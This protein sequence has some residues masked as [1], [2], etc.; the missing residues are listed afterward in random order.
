MD[1]RVQ[2]QY[3]SYPYPLRSPNDDLS[4]SHTISTLE[5]LRAVNHYCFRGQ[6]DWTRPFR[7]LVAGGGTGDSSTALGQQLQAIGCEGEVVY[8]DLSKTSLKIARDRAKAAGLSNVTFL[9]GSLLEVG[10]M[11]LGKFDYINCSGVLHHLDEPEAGMLALSGV[12]APHGAMGIMIYGE[13]G[14]TGVY[15]AQQMLRLLNKGQST[16][17]MVA[18]ARRLLPGLPHSNWLVKNNECCFRAELDDTEIVDRFLHSC[19]RAY[20]VPTAVKLMASAGMH[21]VDFVPSL[22][23]RLD[24]FL[25]DP[26][27]LG[28]VKALPRFDQYAFVEL[29]LGVLSKLSFFTVSNPDALSLIANPQ[30]PAVVPVLQLSSGEQL[31]DTIRQSGRLALD[32]GSV[33]MSLPLEL[34]PAIEATIR[35][36][37]GRTS[38]QGM[39]EK[40]S[41][42]H[43]LDWKA[44]HEGFIALY[45]LLA[46]A[47]LLVLTVP[48]VSAG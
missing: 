47:S 16:P 13:L 19:D 46:D 4:Q 48:A 15:H 38:L 41:A 1:D 12:L 10:A 8:L 2:M 34:T 43:D 3:E 22:L 39:F 20:R 23:Y 44:F 26:E 17:E 7:I 29:Y 33:K 5:N 31:A 30:D 14:R 40:V 35:A 21:I 6:H 24:F 37:D 28:R 9:Q 25:K 45:H 42:G 32:L 18:L 27:I 36:I 11:E